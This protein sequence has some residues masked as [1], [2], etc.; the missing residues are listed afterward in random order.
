MTERSDV[1]AIGE[2][3][4]QVPLF[5]GLSRE[6]LAQ[7]AGVMKPRR[8][9]RGQILFLKGDDGEHLFVI[10][11]GEIKLVLS[12]GDGQESILNVLQPGDAFGEM[13]LFDEQ[14]RSA[15][16]VAS[17]ETLLLSLHRQEF[18]ELNLRFP[19][20]AFPI[21]RTLTQRLRR[22]TDLLEESLFFDLGVRLA[23]LL[24]RLAQEHGRQTAVGIELDRPITQQELAEMVNA[25]RPRVNEQLQRLRRQKIIAMERRSLAILRPEALQ[26]LAEG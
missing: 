14:P 19:E 21:Y 1:P 4:A 9:S 13:A 22:T 18:R 6:I 10:R 2:L 12:G 16:A 8:L 25:T 20:M 15:D 5:A 7:V 24:L 11:A 3:L 23:R 26:R 17:Q